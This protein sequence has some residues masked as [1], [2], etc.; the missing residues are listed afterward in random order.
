M[1][2]DFIFFHG[3]EENVL[4]SI[5]D[6]HGIHLADALPKLRGLAHFAEEQGGEFHRIEAVA[7]V[8]A[9]LRVLDLKD[10]AVRKAV[11]DADEVENLYRSEV[12]ARY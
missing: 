2:P 10:G 7:E 11:E 12:A 6:P 5:V 8:D 1:C 3:T 4:A 9:H